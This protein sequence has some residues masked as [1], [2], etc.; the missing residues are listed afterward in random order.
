MS[1]TNYKIFTDSCCDL[2][3]KMADELELTV[4]P[5]SFRIGDKEY[6]NWLDGREMSCKQFFTEL[7]AGKKASTS[8]VSVGDFEDA[9][10]KEAAAGNDVLYLAFSS[11]LSTTYNS[12][13][14]AAAAVSARHPERKIYVVDTLAAS[15][16][17]GLLLWYAVGKKRAGMDIDALRQWV[18]DNRQHFDHWFTVDDLMHLMRGGR[19]SA[20]AAVAGTLIG[21][22][23]VMHTDSEG[24]LTKVSVVRGRKSSLRTLLREMERLGGAG[25]KGQTCMICHSDCLQESEELAAQMKH[26]FGVRDVLINWIGPVI[27]AHTGPGTIGI[28]FYGSE[29]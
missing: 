15:L 11:A 3:Q 10:E 6:K 5:L 13:R 24:R 23:P 14:L 29:R 9:F 1:E 26:D 4:L 16:G 28:F 27:G 22:K 17:Q 20:A 2:P 12:G 18:E 21:I 19:V 25:L 7:Q 8:A